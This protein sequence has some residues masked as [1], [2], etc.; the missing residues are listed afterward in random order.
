LQILSDNFDVEDL[1][2]KMSERPGLVR[3]HIAVW[4]VGAL[5]FFLTMPL[6][7]VAGIVSAP[8][9]LGLASSSARQSVISAAE[10]YLG[11]PYRFG[12]ATKSGIDCS[13]LVY[14]SYLQAT[15]IKIP[16]TVDSLATWV[17]VIPVH[18][19][20]PGDLVFFD[21]DAKAVPSSE[22][23]KTIASQTAASLTRA[24]HV[25]IYLGDQ[26]F[27]H[28]AST[29]PQTGVI[30]SSLSEP[31]WG[32][33]FLFAGRALPTSAL[34][35][36]AVDWGGGVSF[37]QLE[38]LQGGLLA[39]VRGLS[40]WAEVS[41][42][43]SKNF[44]AGLRAGANWDRALGVVRVPVEL[45]LGQI[46]GFSVFAGP[47]FTFGSP[48][49]DD[50]LYS[51]G[52]FFLATGGIRWSPLFFSSGAQRFGTYFELRYDS[53]VPQPGQTQALQTDL[54]A[55]LNFSIGIRLRTVKY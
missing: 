17:L 53:Y 16:R 32:R 2:M 50:R 43:I 8:P 36:F 44:S 54:R 55:C 7:T 39:L 3:R 47:A 27:I 34:S 35:G 22:Q 15:G 19:L 42:P 4:F 30:Q 33:R 51:P 6:R 12:G 21:L 20:E 13:G 28:A 52:D 45:S 38:G 11:T 5:L 31:G 41:L 18:E 1:R 26:R 9:L 49:L 24:D 48:R 10:S 23:A 29:G 37:A 14:V 40:G 46:S 25:G